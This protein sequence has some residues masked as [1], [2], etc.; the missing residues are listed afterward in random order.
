MV[1]LNAFSCYDI[2]SLVVAA[3]AAAALKLQIVLI[4]INFST[5]LK[6]VLL[7]FLNM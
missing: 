3:T 7:L 4:R 6:C 1:R 2:I 5:Y